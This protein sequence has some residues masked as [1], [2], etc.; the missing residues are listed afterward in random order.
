M[1]LFSFLLVCIGAVFSN[2][3]SMFPGAGVAKIP[4]TIIEPDSVDAM[5]KKYTDAVCT[6]VDERIGCLDKGFPKAGS[7]LDNINK[8]QSPGRNERDCR[9][10]R[11]AIINEMVFIADHNYQ[12]YEGNIVAGRAKNNF[13]TGAIRT[14]LETAGALITVADTTR[15]LSGL[16]ALTGTI[17]ESADKE[18]FFDNTIDALIIQ[19]RADRANVLAGMVEGRA[20][21]YE[22]YSIEQA[23]GDITNYYRAGTL[24]SAVISISNS[25]TAAQDEALLKLDSR[26]TY[27]K[28]ASIEG[29]YRTGKADEADEADEADGAKLK[30][31]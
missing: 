19:M 30:K 7:W 24:A 25:A 11:N 16:A 9:I 31:Q 3:C 1:R 8:C 10:Y 18:F 6:G 21:P 26:R 17:Q 28:K 4:T 14:T 15:I 5:S 20:M 2:G 22:L 13:Y 23:V 27:E 12:A 29:Y